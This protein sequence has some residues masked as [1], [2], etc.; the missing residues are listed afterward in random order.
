MI[1]FGPSCL[2]S[3][4]LWAEFDFGNFGIF[5]D[6]HIWHEYWCSFQEAEDISISC[7]NLFFDRY[8]TNMSSCQGPS[9]LWSKLPC[10]LHPSFNGQREKTRTRL[11]FSK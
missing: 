4:F 7:K 8:K 1:L 11:E 10:G 3:S 6:P 2:S 5:L 9:C